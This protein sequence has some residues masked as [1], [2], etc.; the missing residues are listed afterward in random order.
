VATRNRQ[1]ADASERDRETNI[2]IQGLQSMVL[3]LTGNDRPQALTEYHAPRT[4][5]YDDRGDQAPAD[6]GSPDANSRNTHLPQSPEPSRNDSH[7]TPPPSQ[8]L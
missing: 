8:T 7:E 4:A 1:L 6:E 3:Q 5:L 2:L